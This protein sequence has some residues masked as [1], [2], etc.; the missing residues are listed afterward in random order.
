MDVKRLSVIN[1]VIVNRCKMLQ[2]GAAAEM[3]DT[4][5]LSHYPLSTMEADWPTTEA[6]EQLVRPRVNTDIENW[7][8][9]R[10][11]VLADGLSGRAACREYNAVP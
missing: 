1:S 10:R 7:A 11:R 4:L 2:R 3:G 6:T 5:G 8:Q 9:I